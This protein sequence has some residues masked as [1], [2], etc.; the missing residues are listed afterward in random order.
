MAYK[1][2]QLQGND[3]NLKRLFQTTMGFFFA[4]TMEEER[5]VILQ[6]KNR[7]QNSLAH[8]NII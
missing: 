4:G 1:V 5:A 6:K 2:I 7:D 8:Y 3:E